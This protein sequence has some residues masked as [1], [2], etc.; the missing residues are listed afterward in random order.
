MKYPVLPTEFSNVDGFTNPE[1]LV[2]YLEIINNDPV[3]RLCKQQVLES[4]EL[5]LGGVG[6]ISCDL[7]KKV[8][9]TGRV[10]GIDSSW[11]MVESATKRLCHLDPVSV[12]FHFQDAHHLCFKEASFDAGL[13]IQTLIH[14]KNPQRVLSE[15][16][17]VV[18]PGRKVAVME[19][20][21][22]MLA[23][24]TGNPDADNIL[25][26]LLR[27]SVRNSG[28]GHQLPTLMNMANFTDISVA[29]GTIMAFDFPTAN[30]AWHIQD[31][32]EHA[33]ATK[34]LSESELEMLVRELTRS[35]TD[36]TFFGAS[37][38]FVVTA[39]R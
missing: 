4:L 22:Q 33:T 15:L 27:G 39:R 23:I 25:N 29:A 14:V 18:R 5:N 31:A 2:E 8:G 7:A 11:T 26:S 1:A 20:D 37:T 38:G 32:V 21:W 36:G 10:V 30:R 3:L 13:I 24:S 16:F 12:R 19:S 35:T 28:I 6:H 34:M 17:R 9:R